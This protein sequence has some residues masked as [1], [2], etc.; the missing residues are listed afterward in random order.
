MLRSS[1][2]PSLG[3]SLRPSSPASP[4]SAEPPR[5]FL[6]A[7]QALAPKVACV[8]DALRARGYRV[9]VALGHRARRWVRNV[10]P[11]PPSVRVLCVAQIDREQADRLRQGR[12]DFHIVSLSTPVEVVTEIERL[13]GRTRVRRRPRPSRMYLAQPTLIEQQLQAQR[14]WGWTAVAGVVLLTLGT[15][16]GAMLGAGP[17][18]NAPRE[19]AVTVRVPSPAAA[20]TTPRERDEPVLSAVRPIDP[21]ALEGPDEHPRDSTSARR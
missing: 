8:E 4:T 10:P 6:L 18:P 7:P 12:D 17:R 2:D 16:A 15:V 1:R 14:G 19:P 9:R 20:P 11:G 13:T 21:E 5:I 3:S